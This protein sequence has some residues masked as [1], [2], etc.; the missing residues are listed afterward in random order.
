MPV[1]LTNRGVLKILTITVVLLLLLLLAWGSVWLN[2]SWSCRVIDG[3]ELSH[4]QDPG[5]GKEVWEK[6]ELTSGQH[7]TTQHAVAGPDL[8][9]RSD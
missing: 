9:F 8:A 2:K 7:R 6:W 4:Q 3:R 1:I 5:K